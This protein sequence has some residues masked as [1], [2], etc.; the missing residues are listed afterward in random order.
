MFSCNIYRQLQF[1]V[2]DPQAHY[3]DTNAGQTP[4]CLSPN[5]SNKLKQT[6]AGTVEVDPTQRFQQVYGFGGGLTNSAAYLIHY[7]S[8]REELLQT[9]FSP[10]DG[11][12]ISFIRLPMGASDFMARGPAY[13]FDDT[14]DPE[15]ENFSID[16]ELEFVIPTILAAKEVNPDLKIIAAPWTAP[17][18]MKS[19]NDYNSGYFLSEYS[20]VYANYFLKYLQ[21]FKDNGVIIDA[22]SLQNEPVLEREY[23]T[24]L[25]SAKDEANISKILGPKL[26]E[27]GIETKIV[28][29]DYDWDTVDYALEVL[30]DD[31][32]RENIDGFACHGYGGDPDG[33][34]DVFAVY[35]E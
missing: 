15:L 19:N 9:L 4:G 10:T 30:S 12:G 35:P 6:R 17:P 11:V 14:Y 32:A 5:E 20:E 13:T 2:T 7:S 16:S 1:W 3:N 23:P 18:W 21:G 34:L 25:L 8:R 31:E 28:I 29:W 26:R 27:A 33:A 24:M 22:L